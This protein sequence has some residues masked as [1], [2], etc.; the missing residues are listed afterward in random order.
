MQ[1]KSRGKKG[2]RKRNQDSTVQ[3]EEK[4]ETAEK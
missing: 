4:S 1:N 3:K 2:C